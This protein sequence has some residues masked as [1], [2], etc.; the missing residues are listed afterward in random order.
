LYL[1]ADAVR[2]NPLTQRATD[3]ELTTATQHWLRF[4]RDREGGR[5]RRAGWTP[6]TQQSQAAGQQ[7]GYG[8]T[9]FEVQQ[10]MRSGTGITLHGGNLAVG[11]TPFQF[12]GPIDTHALVQQQ[13]DNME[14]GNRV[15]G[16]GAAVGQ[17]S[18]ACAQVYCGGAENLQP[19]M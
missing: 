6:A 19:W 7:G 10:G 9:S 14:N 5:Q 15:G 3:K 18:G 8:G 11:A 2:R 13:Q 4:T 12:H 16:G 1:L 17:S